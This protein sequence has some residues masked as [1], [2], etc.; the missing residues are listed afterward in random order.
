MKTII[1]TL[2]AQLSDGLEKSTVGTLV[3]FGCFGCIAY[4][5]A[6][7]GGSDT[8]ESLITT[9]MIV[10]ATLMG[11]NS[12]TDIFKVNKTSTTSTTTIKGGCNS[13]I[14]P[15]S[16]TMATYESSSHAGEQVVDP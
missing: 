16:T 13:A 1:R 10:A 3:M 6:K 7:E 4:L 15:E 14:P 12:V 11:V 8:V 5:T 2:W 9:A